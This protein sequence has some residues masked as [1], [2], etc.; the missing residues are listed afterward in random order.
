MTNRLLALSAPPGT[1]VSDAPP[2][3]YELSPDSWAERVV[4]PLEEMEKNSGPLGLVLREGASQE[5]QTGRLPT[6]RERLAAEMAAKAARP[7]WGETHWA[8]PREM[9]PLPQAGSNIDEFLRRAPLS[10][11][12]VRGGYVDGAIPGGMPAPMT[13]PGLS[14]APGQQPL[15]YDGGIPRSLLPALGAYANKAPR[16]YEGK[17]HHEPQ[18]RDQN[19]RVPGPLDESGR[20]VVFPEGAPHRPSLFTQLAPQLLRD[21]ID[22]DNIA[23]NPAYH[24]RHSIDPLV[25]TWGLHGVNVAGQSAESAIALSALGRLLGRIKPGLG[26]TVETADVLRKIP[27]ER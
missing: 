22:L 26:E 2:S 17:I 23:R 13:L 19:L 25:A 20:E 3:A 15:H 21:H 12:G 4:R 11:A 27:S 9:L 10:L 1:E 7:N 5:P 8:G 24:L 6:T 16:P 14:R 18:P